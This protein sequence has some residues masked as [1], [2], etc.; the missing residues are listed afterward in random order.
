MSGEGQTSD[1]QSDIRGLQDEVRD[2]KTTCGQSKQNTEH[3]SPPSPSGGTRSRVP[4]GPQPPGHAVSSC[5][6]PGRPLGP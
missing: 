2:G 6:Y 5:L 4:A 3:T 1:G